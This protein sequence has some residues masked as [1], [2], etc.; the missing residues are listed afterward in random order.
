LFLE[1]TTETQSPQR[2]STT[3]YEKNETE[4]KELIITDIK[5]EDYIA[6]V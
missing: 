6:V 2:K 4:L 1:I 5:K 3:F